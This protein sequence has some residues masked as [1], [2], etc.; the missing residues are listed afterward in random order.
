MMC[1]FIRIPT[2]TRSQIILHKVSVALAVE[3]S[4]WVNLLLFFILHVY[5]ILWILH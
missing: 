2:S 1:S 4:A 3:L 5:V